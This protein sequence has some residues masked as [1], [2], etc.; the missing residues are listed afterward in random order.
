MR[1]GHLNVLA[2]QVDNGIE[3][4]VG[5]AVAQQVFQSVARKDAPAVVHDGK[6]GVQVGIVAQ[7]D[8]HNVVM[9]LIVLEQRVVRFKIYV[10][11]VLVGGVFGHVT[12]HNALLEGC[13]AHLTVAERAYLEM[14]AQR[15]YGLHAHAVQSDALLKGLR[16]IL[17]AGV[18]H[19]DRLNEFSL[20]DASAVVTH[21]DPQVVFNGYLNTVTG[22]H[23]KLVNGVVNDFFQQHINAV[24]RQ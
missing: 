18:Q 21:A 8:L 17:T 23:L 6:T 1:K 9:E 7:H 4:I 15:V 14:S 20:G 16:V 22:L 2:L 12:L 3:G 5:H 10:R 19:A 13:L 11:A 24:L